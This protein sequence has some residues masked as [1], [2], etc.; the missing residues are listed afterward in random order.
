MT[1]ETI[2]NDLLAKQAYEEIDAEKEGREPKN[3]LTTPK[4]KDVS[5]DAE[6]P[7]NSD[8]PAKIEENDGELDD[9]N[10]DKADKDKT[11]DDEEGKATEEA[12]DDLD[13]KI[14]A[15][16]EKH[17]LTY[18]EA[19]EDLDKTEEILKQYKNDPA[20][21]ARAMRN[22]DREYHKL[23]A[24]AEK[25]KANKEP[26]F[27]RMTDEQFIEFA[28][29]ELN[30]KPEFVTKF[31]ERFPAKSEAMSDEAV[32]EEIAERELSVY[33]EKATAKENEIKSNAAKKRD[34]MIAQLPESDRRFIPDVKALIQGIDDTSILHNDDLIKD[35]LSMVKGRKYDADIKAAEE[36][37]Y[38]RAKE[39]AH[40]VGVKPS[41]E[42][43]KGAK[44]KTGI[45]LNDKQKAR[46]EQMFGHSYEPE[47]CHRLFKE[48][49]DEEL[50]KDPKFV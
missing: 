11:S 44:T 47:E 13:K 35:A 49:F 39:G 22:K 3:L 16:A 25:A 43:S 17:K 28:K 10:E 37:G 21:M 4:K 2:D 23:R 38:K 19:K 36:R 6:N 33:R 41:A 7:E 32:I 42:G 8:A 14:T 5:E 40:I 12:G 50:K 26:A 15:Y 45:I 18:A 24:E 29:A 30:K 46:A 9:S 27:K 34:E 31:R 1:V 48:T 20:E